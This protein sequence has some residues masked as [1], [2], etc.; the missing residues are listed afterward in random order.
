MTRPSPGSISLLP[1]VVACIPML[2]ACG[3]SGGDG[4]GSAIPLYTDVVTLELAIEDHLSDG[5]LKLV[6]PVDIGV[7]ARGNIYL[8]DDH[9]VKVFRPDGTPLRQIGREGTGPGEF[10]RALSVHVGPTGCVAAIDDHWETNIYAPDGEFISRYRS[11]NEHHFRAYQQERG[12]TSSQLNEVVALRPDRLLIDLDAMNHMLPGPYFETSQLLYATPDTL[13]ELCHYV[14]KEHVKTGEQQTGGAWFQGSLIWSLLDGERILFTETGADRVADGSRS[15]YRMI[16]LDLTTLSTDTLTVPWVPEPVPPAVKYV[17][18]VYIAM[19][20]RSIEVHPV[21]RE[22]MAETEYYPPLKAVRADRG[23]IFGFHFSPI[24]S[25]VRVLDDQEM[26]PHLT[27]II[28]LS[29][30]R[31]LARAEFPFLPDVIRDGKAYRLF[32]PADDYSA[33][34]V[35]RIDRRLY[36]LRRGSD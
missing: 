28:D 4:S 26:E 7:D 27:D 8:A 3:R 23:I 29:T 30:G 36:Q 19:L 6:R 16:V 20:D 11:R 17:E 35:Y 33:V 25:V 24:D 22:I 1:L 2:T 21:V 15:R 10:I 31:L 32:R 5:D 9:A 18:S 12:F 13:L 34:H 14:D